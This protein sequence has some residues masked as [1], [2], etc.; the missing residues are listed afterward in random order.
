M[1][2]SAAFDA[3]PEYVRE[4]VYQRLYDILTGK[5]QSSPYVRL[6]ADERRSVLEILRDTKPNLPAYWI[7]STK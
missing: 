1:I 7:P 5:D 6:S 3:M 4:R 2:Y